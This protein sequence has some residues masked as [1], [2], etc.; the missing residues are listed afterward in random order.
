MLLA[1]RGAPDPGALEAGRVDQ[2]AGRVADWVPE[3]AAG[4]RDAQR[5]V[6]LAPVPD[7]IETLADLVRGGGRKAER[8][9][10]DDI[11][12]PVWIR[13]LEPAVAIAEAQLRAGQAHLCAVAAEHQHRLDDAS[14]V[15]IVGARIGPDG[16]TDRARDGQPELEPGQTGA[17]GHRGGPG[18]RH[19]R[20]RAE[21]IVADLGLLGAHLDDQAADPGIGDD[22]IAAPPEQEVR[23]AAGPGELDQRPQLERV[24]RHREQV[25]RA[26]DAHRREPGQR[27]V[28]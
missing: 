12:Q 14:H 1:D 18:H 9:A 15:G 10:Q 20:L 22:H 19:A 2:P 26:T 25:G 5:L 7:R 21:P 24:V 4:A 27:L 6:R 8:G 16:A 23:H 11:R 17:L 3:V 28:S 13:M